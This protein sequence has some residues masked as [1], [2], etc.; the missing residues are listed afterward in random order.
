MGG[1]WKVFDLVVSDNPEV[2]FPRTNP[3]L[4]RSYSTV[5]TDS[6]PFEIKSSWQPTSKWSDKDCCNIHA[7]SVQS[8][9][10]VRNIR[11]HTFPVSRV[12]DTFPPR[13]VSAPPQQ[14]HTYSIIGGKNEIP[15]GMY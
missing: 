13:P 11:V 10:A 15:L 4:K 7:C 14:I 2:Y 8:A 6:S 1:A 9:K 12:Y 5:P 3:R